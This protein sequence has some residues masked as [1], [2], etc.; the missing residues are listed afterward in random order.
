MYFDS[1]KWY[2][3]K[4]GEEVDIES[5]DD[6]EKE[7]LTEYINNLEIELGISNSVPIL[8]KIDGKNQEEK[9]D[10]YDNVIENTST[11]SK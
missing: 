8:Y 11:V 1:K 3:I 7:K 4:S 2:Y 6:K 9:N 10:D 5:L